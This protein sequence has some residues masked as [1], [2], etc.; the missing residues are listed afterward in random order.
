MVAV[1]DRRATLLG[2]GVALTV[3]TVLLLVVGVGDLLA[4][5]GRAD[6]RILAPML[7]VALGWLFAWGLALRTVLS[8]LDVSMSVPRAFAT[9]A[10]ATFANNVTPFGQAGGEPVTA[11][12]IAKST[13]TEYET[14]LAAIASVDALNMVPS[15]G[16]ALLGVGYYATVFTLGRRLR[17]A[18]VAVGLAGIIVLVATYV[19]WARRDQLELLALQFATVVL[20]TLGRWIPRVTPPSQEGLRRR[21]ESF[22]GAIERV[23]T[24]RRRLGVALSYSALGWIGIMT[25]LWLSLYAVGVTVHPAVVLLAVPVAALSAAAPLP[26]GLGGVET[27]LVALLLPIP[28]VTPAG[29]A[30]AIV[31]HRGVT[32]WFPLVIGAFAAG[33]LG[34]R[35]LP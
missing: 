8:V 7:L 26:G 11:L 30:A 20:R 31:L 3:L 23:A 35:K 17:L 1:G 12:L 32:Y 5:L 29:A 24:D 4:A 10:A 16:F 19:G 28:D 14:G 18:A 25:S 22:F 6:R 33:R 2:F 27:I 21:V 9:F 13:D 15:I 34:V